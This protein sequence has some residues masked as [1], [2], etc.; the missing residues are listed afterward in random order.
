MQE[1]GLSSSELSRLDNIITQGK[2]TAGALIPILQDIQDEFG[3]LP[4]AAL[5]YVSLKL[6][7][8]LSSIFGVA[9]FYSQF[10]LQP[11]GK[12]VIRV[13]SGTACHVR[14]ASNVLNTLQEEL[15]IG[16]GE[17]TPD[18]EF[19]LEEVACIGACGLAPAMMINDQTFGRLTKEKVIEILARFRN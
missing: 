14:G 7:T 19:T 8:P 17:T 11:R 6:N 2:G 16:S 1:N 3:Y 4:R 15:K 10:H 18:L 5:E 13:C 12:N 9:T